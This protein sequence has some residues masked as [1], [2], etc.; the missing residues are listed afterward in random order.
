MSIS[1]ILRTFGIFFDHL[2]EFVFILYIFHR[3]GIMY[4]EKSG[5]PGV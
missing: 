4:Q 2:V 5:N 1:N 3:F